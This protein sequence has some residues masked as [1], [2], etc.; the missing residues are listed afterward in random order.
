MSKK[1]L[2]GLA[3]EM[4]E[5]VD[6]AQLFRDR[7]TARAEEGQVGIWIP[8]EYKRRYLAL[9]KTSKFEFGRLIKE[10]LMKCIDEAEEKQAG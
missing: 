2:E 6:F 7:V 4:V 1:L 5:S 8:K 10:V 3:T 9:Q